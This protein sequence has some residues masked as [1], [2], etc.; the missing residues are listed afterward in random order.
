MDAILKFGWFETSKFS[1]SRTLGQSLSVLV[2]GGIQGTDAT[3]C[4]RWSGQIVG[5]LDCFWEGGSNLAQLV[6]LGL[7]SRDVAA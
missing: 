1:K 3:V 6:V 7:I 2:V 5:D 4:S